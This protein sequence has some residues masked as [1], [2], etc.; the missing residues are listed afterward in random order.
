MLRHEITTFVAASRE[1]RFAASDEPYF[2]APLIGF[3]AAADPLFAAYKQ[4][5][6]AF[7]W[8]PEELLVGAA[9]VICWVLPI[10][11]ATRASNRTE[12]QWPSRQWALT[13]H[14]GENFNMALRR[15]LVTW[16][17]ARGQRAVAPQLA[18]GWRSLDDAVVGVASTW[19]ERHAA[20]A[21]GLGTF[22]LNDAL[23][24]PRGIAHRLGSVV[25]DLA[26]PATPRTA[27]DH[28]HN[29]LWFREQSC[30]RCIS[31][32]PVGAINH[33]GHDKT[34]CREYVYGTVAAAVAEPYGVTQTGCGLCQT[35]VPC[36]AQIPGGSKPA[37]VRSGWR[38]PRQ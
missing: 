12:E 38:N 7:H 4:I 13:R 25:T 26:L 9:T 37:T 14:H 36:E 1:N 24:T 34:I 23:I 5:I 33:A 19:S 30:G 27:P 6:G 17:E 18:P 3:A 22:S 20:Y 2:D 15:H 32:C 8:S 28:R 16:L 29:C 21:A 10:P 11:R 35:R 31:R